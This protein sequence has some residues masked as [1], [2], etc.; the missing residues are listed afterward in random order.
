[1][2]TGSSAGQRDTAKDGGK[3]RW[4][5]TRSDLPLCPHCKRNRKHKP[6]DC[7]SLP[8]NADKKPAN[9]IDRRYVNGKKKEGH[10]P[11]QNSDSADNK[12]IIKHRPKCLLYSPVR[13]RNYY[14]PLASQVEELDR[15]ITYTLPPN[16]TDKNSAD[17]RQKETCRIKDQRLSILD[18]SIPSAISDTGTTASAFTPSDPTIAMGIGSTATFGGAFGNQARVTTVNKLHHK[19][20]EP[21]RSTHIVP[22]VQHSLLGTSKLVEA[23]YI[24][25]Y[26]KQEVNFYNATTTKIVALEEAV[27]KEWQCPVTKLWRIPLLDKPD[28]LNTDTLLLDHP[29][30]LE[31]RNKLYE[32]QTNLKSRLHIRALLAQTNKEEYVHN[33]YK[34]PSIELT[35]RYLHTAAKH[36]QKIHG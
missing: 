35:V 30:Q 33:V 4:R 5:K 18:G 23:D 25:I 22:K 32:V 10:E 9:F 26:N 3:E 16:H 21:A 19:I 34:L 1:V 8:A 6:E 15:H 20:R 14:A 28:N 27:L 12:W 29:T 2:A 7:F 31:N 13:T 36:Q 24:A 17:W 11:G